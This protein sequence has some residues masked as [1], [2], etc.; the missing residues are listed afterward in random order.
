MYIHIQPVLVEHDLGTWACG[1]QRI[2]V[3]TFVQLQ[4]LLMLDKFLDMLPIFAS[5]DFMLREFVSHEGTQYYCLRE[6][7]SSKN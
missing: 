1:A 7:K 5:A 4:I 3:E 2:F 6:I